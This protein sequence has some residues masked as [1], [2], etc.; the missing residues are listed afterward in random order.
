MAVVKVNLA[1]PE[2]L[3]ALRACFLTVLGAAVDTAGA[4]WQDSV[5]EFGGEEDFLAL[6]RVVL[7]PVT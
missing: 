3:Q 4:V 6:A 7:E 2:T 5:G 1:D